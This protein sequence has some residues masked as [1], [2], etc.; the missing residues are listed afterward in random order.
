MPSHPIQTQPIGLLGFL[1]LKNS[2]QNPS[3]L[4]DEVQCVLELRDWYFEGDV[5]IRGGLAAAVASGTLGLVLTATQ[6]PQGEQWAIRGLHAT[7]ADIPA[8]D[9]IGGY[10]GFQP[11]N[12]SALNELRLL[13]P[14]HEV[15]VQTDAQEWAP[16]YT[17]QGEMII[18]QPGSTFGFWLTRSLFAAP[19]DFGMV[20]YYTR[21][22][23]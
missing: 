14:F 18:A 2:G 21:M 1:Q 7:G 16:N 12:A 20:V 4:P 17:P 19:V 15:S 6:V 8:G 13:S 5:R 10:I 23:I 11:P 9:A 22:P 3:I